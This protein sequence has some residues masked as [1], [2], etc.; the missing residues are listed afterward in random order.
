MPVSR[1]T[2]ETSPTSFRRPMLHRL[3]LALP[4]LLLLVPAL[5]GDRDTK[6]A[7]AKGLAAIKA[8]DALHQVEVLASPEFGG[9]DTGEPGCEKA[10]EYLA[11]H[12][13]AIGVEPFGDEGEKARSYFQ[14]YPVTVRKL[15]DASGL[16]VHG[17]AGEPR[18]LAANREMAILGFAD[19]LEVKDPVLVV[20]GGTHHAAPTPAEGEEAKGEDVAAPVLPAEAKGAFVLLR[21]PTIPAR[22][23]FGFYRDIVRL[24]R[25]AGATGLLIAPGEGVDAKDYK[26]LFDRSVAMRSGGSKQYGSGEGTSNRRGG[27]GNNPPVVMLPSADAAAALVGQRVSLRWTTVAEEIRPANVVGVIRGSDPALA[28]EFIVHS[29]HYDHVGLQGG[30]LHPGADDNASG[31]SALLEV[32]KAYAASGAPRRSVVFLWVSGEERG[33][34]G[35]QFFV[36]S[37]KPESG[38]LVANLNTDMVGRTK[39][40]GKDRPEYMLMTPSRSNKQFNTLAA[41]AL[42][43]G[44]TYG[45]PDMP[46][47]DKYW[48]RS[49]HYNFARKG[50]PSMFLCNGEHEDYHRP[51]DTADKI[52]GD[53]IARSA[54]LC[55]HLGYEVAMADERPKDLGAAKPDEAKEEAPAE[56]KPEEAK[57]GG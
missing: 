51:G 41:A 15:D 46:S 39:L 36:D 17:E 4:G 47:G 35:S 1:Y 5:G 16:L 3:A 38:A 7:I 52:D 9:R 55:F 44:P 8:A 11:T 45:F 25:E 24:A 48:T 21:V 6:P 49:D 50:I 57:A 28:S 13:K 14:R 10:A 23:S 56:R 54:K 20:D 34:W 37:W 30:E 43:L 33:L 32:A 29:A 53:K 26:A 27:R 31:T 19:P 42:D 18:R 40:N 22:N 2:M 12:L